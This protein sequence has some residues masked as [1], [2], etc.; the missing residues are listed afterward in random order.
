M[1]ENRIK[2]AF[3]AARSA[4]LAGTQLEFAKLVGANP[5]SISRAISGDPVY[6]TEKL[7]FRVEKILQEKGVIVGDNSGTIQQTE[8]TSPDLSGVLAE[9]AAQREMY[10]RHLSE[11]FSIIKSLTTK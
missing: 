3:N 4:G 10:D 9:M 2:R 7:V 1:E 11:A 5:S 6:L 8:T